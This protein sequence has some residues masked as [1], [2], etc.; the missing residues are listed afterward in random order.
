MTEMDMKRLGMQ[1]REILRRIYGPLV[2]HGIWRVR[3]NQEIRE[4][5]KDPDIVGDIVKK[6]LEWIGH[7]VRMDQGRKVK[8]KLEWIGHIVRLD[9][10]RKVKKNW[11]ALDMQLEWIREEKLK[12]KIGMDWTCSQN[13][14]G[15]KS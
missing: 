1:E 12:K 13:G 4:L 14:S 15:K 8:K 2:E 5:Q 3:N 10:G 6:K 7:V 9:Q 11:N